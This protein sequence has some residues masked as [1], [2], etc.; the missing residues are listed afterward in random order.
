MVIAKRNIPLIIAFITGMVML[1]QYYVP[2][3]YSEQVRDVSSAWIRIIAAFTLILGIGSLVN[4]QLVRIRRRMPGYGYAVVVLIAMIIM[5]VTGIFYSQND[6]TLPHGWLIKNAMQPMQSTVFAMLAFF[7]ASASY[8]AF[9][10]KTAEA[11]LLL[12][13]AGVVMLG[14]VPVGENI[15]NFLFSDGFEKLAGNLAPFFQNFSIPAIT[16]WLLKVPNAAGFRGINFGIALGVI[17][18][19][20]RIIFGIERTY[21]GGAD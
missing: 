7:V 6:P 19:A 2:H 20:L 9:R 8:R 18:T 21:L 12:V 1:I 17:A 11:F 16:D 3:H 15:T 13:C 5:T 14:R 4:Y 10:A